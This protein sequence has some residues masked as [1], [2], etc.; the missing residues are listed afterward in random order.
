M[1]LVWRQESDRVADYI[2]LEVHGFEGG[3]GDVV[4]VDDGVWVN[5]VWSNVF[6]DLNLARDAQSIAKFF[7]LWVLNGRDNFD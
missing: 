3:V 4:V 2:A 5:F 7:D 1:D 6:D